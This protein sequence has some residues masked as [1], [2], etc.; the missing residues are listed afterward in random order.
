MS[1]GFNNS[2]VLTQNSP[3]VN[4]ISCFFFFFI[5]LIIV[6]H[7]SPSVPSLCT[8]KYVRQYFTNG[9]LPK[10]GTICEPN[11]ELFDSVTEG[12]TEDDAQRRLHMDINEE[13]KLLLSAI[14]ELSSSQF[15]NFHSPFSTY[16]LD[17]R[18]F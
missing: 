10:P 13:D 15:T 8:M 9:T 4:N 18:M 6:Q 7:C 17:A 2:I 12:S 5:L 14:R 3:G 11:I 16:D 1:R